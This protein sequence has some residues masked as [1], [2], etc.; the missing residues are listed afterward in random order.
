MIEKIK[1]MPVYVQTILQRAS[2]L[3]NTFEVATLTSIA[4]SQ[5]LHASECII[6]Q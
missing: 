6:T 1:K 2:C 5:V 4:A 3:G